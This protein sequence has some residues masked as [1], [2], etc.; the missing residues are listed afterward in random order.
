MQ[1]NLWKRCGLGIG[2][3]AL[4]SCSPMRTVPLSVL[5]NGSKG[6][7]SDHNAGFHPRKVFSR[8]LRDVPPPNLAG[9]CMPVHPG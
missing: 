5:I 7:I 1:D 4:H 9:T 6:L 2:L 8:D 3:G